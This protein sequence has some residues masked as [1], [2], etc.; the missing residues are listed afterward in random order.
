[1]DSIGKL[2]SII[3]DEKGIAVVYIALIMIALVAFV[4]LAIDIGYMYVVKGQL[5]N[6]ADAA[7]LAGASQLP[8]QTAAA[9]KAK[10]FALANKAAAENVVL[11]DSDIVFGHWSSSVQGGKFFPNRDLINAVKVQT[12]RNNPDD[13]SP[14]KQVE[15]FFGK[16]IGWSKMGAVAEAVAWRLP[17]PT[18]PISLCI[19]ACS[20]PIP[21]NL[22]FKQD[23]KF[24]TGPEKAPPPPNQTV[25]WTE[26]SYTSPA[27][28]LGP[29]SLVS[30][31]IRGD[32]KPPDVC[33]QY[34]YTN[35]GQ[36]EAVKELQK[37]YDK[38][39]D[40][41]GN[42]QIV[43]PVLDLVKDHPE[44]L[45]CPPGDQPLPY[46]V[47]R[48]AI[49]NVTAVLKNPDPGIT[50]NSIRCVDCMNANVLG[51]SPILAR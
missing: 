38:E 29:N 11:E 24:D 9:A 10:E 33:H 49:V 17:R 48:Y 25:G 19:N 40:A 12:R 41:S 16:V 43:V 7:A 44:L 14:Q 26:F 5:Q 13:A 15:I 31:Y 51:K 30:K 46:R 28:D 3:G 1:M 47:A 27:T 4:G 8:D 23:K 22:Y 18:L 21:V 42:W 34:I 20:L 35:N 37:E 6:A 32:L 50:V 36:G 39:K 45:A 2:M